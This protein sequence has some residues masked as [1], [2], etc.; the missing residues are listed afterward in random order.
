MYLF[1][2]MNKNTRV[3]TIQNYKQSFHINLHI[4][5]S[6][7]NNNFPIRWWQPDGSPFGDANYIIFKQT[8]NLWILNGFNRATLHLVYYS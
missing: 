6:Y 4:P 7:A 2:I 5:I 3:Y 8:I 1:L